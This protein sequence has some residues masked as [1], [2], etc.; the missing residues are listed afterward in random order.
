LA[1]VDHGHGTGTSEPLAGVLRAGNAGSNTVIDHHDVLTLLLEQLPVDP[2]QTPMLVRVDSAGASHG[3]V[4]ALRDGAIM[5]SVGFPID[6][7]VRDAVLAVPASAMPVPRH[8]SYAFQPPLEPAG[9]SPRCRS[10][11]PTTST[12]RSWSVRLT[13]RPPCIASP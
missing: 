3:F 1:F 12:T 9:T 4:D 13:T 10:D 11:V 8:P 7:N 2:T 5:F 6:A